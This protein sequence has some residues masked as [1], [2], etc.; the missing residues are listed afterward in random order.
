MNASLAPLININIEMHCMSRFNRRRAELRKSGLD[1][2]WR[3][4]D[5]DGDGAG[6][7][8]G[9]GRDGGNGGGDSNGDG[10]GGGILFECESWR[11]TN[12]WS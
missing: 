9:D 5:G 2:R 11:R 3:G 1:Y 10:D 7:G 8:D 12:C 4:G 6:D